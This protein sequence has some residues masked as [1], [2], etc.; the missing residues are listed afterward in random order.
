MVQILL[1]H[2][3]DVNMADREGRSP[4]IHACEK[5]CNDIVRILA[6][7]PDIKPDMADVY[8]EFNMDILHVIYLSVC[9]SVCLSV[10]LSFGYQ[11]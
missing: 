10:C 8:G 3:A 5:R 7:H 2:G 9:M 1:E 6:H 11:A 4:L